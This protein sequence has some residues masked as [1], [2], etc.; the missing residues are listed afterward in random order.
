MSNLKYDVVTQDDPKY[1]YI[2]KMVKESKLSDYIEFCDSENNDILNKI[3]S[4]TDALKPDASKNNYVPCPGDILF[5]DNIPMM[6]FKLS[7]KMPENLSVSAGTRTNV[8]F[9]VYKDFYKR[10]INS[11]DPIINIGCM[12]TNYPENNTEDLDFVVEIFLDKNNLTCF[13]SSRILSVVKFS[14][15]TSDT[16]KNFTINLMK[17]GLNNTTLKAA[18]KNTTDE[19]TTFEGDDFILNLRLWYN[20]QVAL[21]HPTFKDV[22]THPRMEPVTKE[23]TVRKKGKV[24]KKKT[25]KYI[26]RHVINLDDI[27]KKKSNRSFNRRTLAW[28]VIGHWRTCPKSKKKY[29][30]KGYWKGELREAKMH[31]SE[32]RKREVVIPENIAQ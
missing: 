17:A 16:T 23:T 29:F 3:L 26:K 2:D 6:D 25:V 14:P 20:I 13:M 18:L 27:E 15:S 5:M 11:T 22:F 19:K 12:I 7:Y 9:I 30:V 4:L 21:L 32:L 24:V 8:R 1:K 28:Y 10:I 31:E